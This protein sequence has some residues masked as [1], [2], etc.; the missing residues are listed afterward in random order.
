M[1]LLAVVLALL[2]CC[3]TSAFLTYDE[4][5]KLHNDA[6]RLA[7]AYYVTVFGPR[8]N[9]GASRET[10]E[11]YWRGEGCHEDEW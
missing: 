4:S 7:H 3:G 11:R 10:L 2:L 6:E 8:I 9:K 5:K 1:R